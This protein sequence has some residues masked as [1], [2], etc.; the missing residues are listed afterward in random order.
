MFNY[1]LKRLDVVNLFTTSNES[2]VYRST[3]T[4]TR[5]DL[6]LIQES[7]TPNTNILGIV[8]I[9]PNLFINYI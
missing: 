2:C 8:Y 1:D 7:S 6:A 4:L 3:R 9:L 5:C